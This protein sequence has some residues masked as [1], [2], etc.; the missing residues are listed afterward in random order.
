MENWQSEYLQFTLFIFTTVWFVQKGSPESKELHKVG[1]EPDEDQ[2]IGEHAHSDSPEW[3]RAQGIKLFL[4]SNSL[5]IVMGLIWLGSWFAQSVTGWSTYNAQQIEHEDQTLNWLEY[6]GSAP[7]SGRARWRTGSPSSW[8]SARWRCWRSTCA[9][10]DRRSRSRSAP[11]TRR[12]AS[13]V[14]RARDRATVI[15][16]SLHEAAAVRVPPPPGRE[17]RST[18]C[19]PSTATRPRS[20]PA[21]RACSRS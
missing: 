21:A 5:L 19:S 16:V 9:S 17:R 13:R 14:W 4:C 15:R 12:P 7:T 11:L 2:R 20:S 8:R 10:A 1:L 18:T 3:A 6:I